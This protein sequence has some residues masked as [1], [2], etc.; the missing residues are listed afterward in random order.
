M[1]ILKDTY[2]F[3]NEIVLTAPILIKTESSDSMLLWGI[4]Y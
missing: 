3:K 2:L 1:L 4:R